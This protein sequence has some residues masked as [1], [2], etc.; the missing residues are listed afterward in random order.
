MHIK[1]KLLLHTPVMGTDSSYQLGCLSRTEGWRLEIKLLEISE[2]EEGVVALH[3][4]I[5]PLKIRSV[6]R[7][8]L[9]CEP[10]TYQPI[11][12]WYVSPRLVVTAKMG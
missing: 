5:G 10:S 8:V 2:T 7:P 4:P 12:R 1:S 11:C 3:L 6:L 9:R